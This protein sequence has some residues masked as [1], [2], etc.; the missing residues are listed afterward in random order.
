MDDKNL[1]FN[2]LQRLFFRA[3]SVLVLFMRRI[4]ALF[5]LLFYLSVQTSPVLACD[6]CGCSSSGNS[7]GLLSLVPRHFIGLR[8]QQQHFKTLAH[9]DETASNEQ[10]NTLDIWARWHP[11]R[12][13]QIVGSLPYRST[14]RHYEAAETQ[15]FQGL[16]DASLMG[17]YALLDP[18]IQSGK[19][20]QHS[21]QLGGGIK[22]PTG[23]SNLKTDD[24]SRL[25]PALQPGTGSVDYLLSALYAIRRGSIGLSI[26]ATA[27]LCGPYQNYQFGNR[28][29]SGLRGFWVKKL[30]K[31]T[32]LPMI[33]LSLD[34][35]DADRENGIWQNESGG[36]GLFGLAGVEF[37]GKNWSLGFDWQAP[38]S[39]EFS[40]GKVKP[41]NRLNATITWMIG[42]DKIR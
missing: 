15:K 37:F 7:M 38:I 14:V 10:F 32:I 6:V 39:S 42:K 18:K 25:T 11:T 20:W 24:N 22:L 41:Q 27:R 31:R 21:F 19:T 2:G 17:Y 36:W 13:I 40:E 29:N 34:A 16:G 3:H 1:V 30:K 4:F 35:R 26:D 12:R 33:G 28:I 5:A 23:K 8:W 9:E